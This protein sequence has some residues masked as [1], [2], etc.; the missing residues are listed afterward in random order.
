MACAADA[1]PDTGVIKRLTRRPVARNTAVGVAAVAVLSSCA[2][3]A[4]VRP[5]LVT[6]SPRP[7]ATPMCAE[8]DLRVRGPASTV[9]T[10]PGAVTVIV[11]RNA[12][13]TACSLEGWPKVA[14]LGPRPGPA[15][16]PIRYGTATGAW[17]IAL[18]RVLLRPGASAAASMLIGTPTNASGCDSP[19]WAVTP[20]Q[21]VRREVVHEPR[22]GPQVCVGDSIVVSPVYPGDAPR[23]SYPPSAATPAA[24]D[25]SRASPS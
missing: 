9:E 8:H 11:F 16:V 3:P 2:S 17:S 13:G 25:T 6:V 12:G 21:G 19:A 14:I 15:A 24:A 23:V 7:K 22:G 5:A 1:V 20:P 4:A 18:T 10:M